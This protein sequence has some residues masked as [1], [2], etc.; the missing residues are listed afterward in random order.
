M[1]ASL[2]LGLMGSGT[3]SLVMRKFLRMRKTRFTC[4]QDSA[5]EHGRIGRARK[6]V[7]IKH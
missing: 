5:G 3:L 6:S 2:P 4:R 7:L 1:E